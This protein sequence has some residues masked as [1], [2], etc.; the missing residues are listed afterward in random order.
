M[1]R[2]NDEESQQRS[3][4][5]LINIFLYVANVCFRSVPDRHIL[6]APREFFCFK[7]NALRL[8]LSSLL[9][10]ASTERSQKCLRQLG[11]HF[12]RAG[13]D[14]PGRTSSVLSDDWEVW[15]LS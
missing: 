14:E 9:T 12:S 6:L 2:G 7:W 4:S 15:S 1:D 8:F 13:P 11:G 10:W 3:C 5:L